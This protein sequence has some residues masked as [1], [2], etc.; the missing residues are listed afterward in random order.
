MRRPRLRLVLVLVA[1]LL[2]G[3][4][5]QLIAHA[6][7][8]DAARWPANA[9]MT[10]QSRLG[11]AWLPHVQLVGGKWDEKSGP[12][13][14]YYTQNSTNG[15]D[16]PSN[17]II[18]ICWVNV[19]LT[20]YSGQAYY[21]FEGYEIKSCI[22]KLNLNMDVSRFYPVLSHEL[23]H[24]LGLGHIDCDWCIMHPKLHPMDFPTEY[25]GNSLR[26][27]YSQNW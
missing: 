6:G 15:C 5:A 3:G 18:G 25:D 4:T 16:H 12:I 24:C 23:G 19:P 17:G 22:V 8:I 21:E 27:L 1:V 11:S 13:S 14:F 20:W 10:I 26:I 2:M 7:R 9:P